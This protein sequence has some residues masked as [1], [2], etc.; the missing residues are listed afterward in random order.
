MTLEDFMVSRG[1]KVVKTKI[2]QLCGFI[3]HIL[4][5]ANSNFNGQ[6]RKNLI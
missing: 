6:S 4:K 3:K 5:P 1:K 2:Q